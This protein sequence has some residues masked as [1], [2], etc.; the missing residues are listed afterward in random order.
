MAR[1]VQ[2]FLI[3]GGVLV[4]LY[5]VHLNLPKVDKPSPLR[6]KNRD[7]NLG[8][9]ILN[10]NRREYEKKKLAVIV[11]VRGCLEN[12]LRFVPHMGKFLSAQE[13]PYH[14]FM[15]HQEDELRFNRAALINIGFLYTKD[16]YDYTV[17]HDVDL[18]PMNPKLSYEYPKEENSVFHVMNT[19]FHPSE[20][21]RN[22]VSSF[23]WTHVT[24]PISIPVHVLPC[25]LVISV[26]FSSFPTKYT[27][28][29]TV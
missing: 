28:K 24:S 5:L 6:H 14:I 23:D 10:E 8:N 20:A 15:V 3:F 19:Y 21:Y 27:R 17:Q 29:S 12:V 16:K 18:L 11:P 4:V 2:N 1:T 13:I 26:E 25:S 9:L 22:L 7:F